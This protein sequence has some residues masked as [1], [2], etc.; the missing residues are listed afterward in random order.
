MIPIN[1]RKELVKRLKKDLQSLLFQKP[2]KVADEQANNVPLRFFEQKLPFKKG[3][4]DTRFPFVLVE[5]AEG[6][7]KSQEDDQDYKVRMNFLIGIYNDSNENSGDDDVIQ[8]LNS[9]MMNLEENPIVGGQFLLDPF[10]EVSW[11][12]SDE[13]TFPYYFG[14]L[15]TTFIVPKVVR[16]DLERGGFI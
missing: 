15:S 1:L 5:L 11:S 7:Q 13:D 2:K 10:E 16:T 14:G 9:I 3:K 12:I 4:T 6:I 8:L